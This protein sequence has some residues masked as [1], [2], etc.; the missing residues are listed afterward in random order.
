M[1][2]DAKKEGSGIMKEPTMTEKELVMIINKQRN[3]K[4]F[5]VDEIRA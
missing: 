2:K 5:G 1:E 4:A 3:G